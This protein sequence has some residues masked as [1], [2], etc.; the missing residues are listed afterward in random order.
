MEQLAALLAQQAEESR[1]RE[2]RMSQLLER[3]VS[4]REATSSEDGQ[5]QA[6]PEEVKFPASAA[7][8]PHLSSSASLRE[9][10][11][12]RHKFR[13]Y[14]A[15][16]KISALPLVEQKA[17]LSSVVDDEWSRTLRF[18]IDAADDAGLEQVLDAMEAHLR[19]QRNVIVDR[20]EFYARVQQPGESFDD[21]LCAVKEIVNFCDFCE[22][23][24][25]NRLR[26]RIVV[27]TSDEG[28]LKRMLKEKDLTLRSA[29][30]ICRASESAN[31]NS[32]AIRN[33]VDGTVCK[34]SRYRRERTS[35]SKG[36]VCFRC[37]QKNHTNKEKC[38]AVD[39]DCLNCGKL[40]HFAAVCRSP[41]RTSSDKRTQHPSK[42]S[43]T[44]D[45][46]SKKRA[47]DIHRVLSGVYANE[48]SARPAPKV[49]I[50]A[51]HPGGRDRVTWT[52][53]SGAEATVMGL[54]V[55]QSLG[56]PQDVLEVPDRAD[57]LAAGDYP[58]TC[59]GTFTSQLELGNKRTKT[60]VSV[61]KEVKGALLSWFDSVALGILPSDFPAQIQPVKDSRVPVDSRVADAPPAPPVVLPRWPHAHDPTPKQREEHANTLIRAFPRVFGSSQ[62]LREMDGGPMHIQLTEDAKPFAVTASR[63]I[64]YSWRAEIKAQL[65]D[66]LAKDIITE[67]DY[68][69][70]WC[71][72]IVPIAKKTTGVRLCVDLTR[73]NRYVKRPTYPVQSPNDAIASME[74][75]AAWFTTMD[76]KMGYF[77]IKIA[78][79]DQDLTCF[80]TPWG[81]FKFKRAPMGLVSSGDEYNR[82]GDQALG[83]SPRTVKIVDDILAYDTKY[84]DHLA[85]V[86]SIL[87]R[88]DRYGITLNADKFRFAR[89]EV[90][91]CG[92][93]ITSQGYTADF[94]KM[95]A[96]ADFP[97]P[98]NLTD[99]RSFMGLV[100]QLGGFSS[101]I[102]EASQ[103]LRDLLKPRNDWCWSPQHEEAFD[104]VKG[105]LVA[106]PVLAYFD[107]TLPT[108]LQTDAS[109][110]NGFGFVL[111]QKHNDLW[112]LV[113]CGSRFL[114]DTESRYAVIELELAAVL[115]SV[116]KCSTYLT[117]LPHFDL[118]V[119][120]RP[121]VPILN[122]KLLSEIENPR[123]QRIR[124]KLTAYTF[125]ARW[126]K[127]SL[128]SAP[129]ALSRAPVQDPE[130]SS[131]KPDSPEEVDPL[132]IAVVNALTD[133]CEE[134]IRLAPL[135][136]Q[137]L[138]KVR[139]AA[140]RD[141]E[142]QALRETIINGFPEHRHE[143]E[144]QLRSY[145]SV[146][147]QLALDE[148]LIVYGPRLLIPR[149]LRRET[150]ALLHDSHQGMDRT[151][152]RA[153]QTTY[154]PGID[155][156][157]ENVVSSCQ[158]C[159]P[160]LPKQQHE[161]LWQDDDPP[162]RV[163]QSV[164]ADYFHVAGR[165]YLVYVDRLSGWPYVTSCPREASAAHLVTCLR[166]IFADTGV[167]VTLRT[168]GGP[169][170]ASSTLRRFLA[171]WGV[172]H[173]VTSPYNPRANG[174]AEAAV[175]TVKKLITTTTRRGQLDE[176]EF[177]RGLLELR[178]TPSAAGRSPAQV[179][180]GHPM[181]SSVPA[182]HRSFASEWQRAADDCDVTA[183]RLKSKAKQR[184][185]S[186]ARPLPR[187][188]IGGYVDV[189]DH[190]SGRWDRV[191]VIVGIG[192]RRD[193]LIK[194]GSGRILWR[195][196]KFLRPHHPMLPE[197]APRSATT[198]VIQPERDGTLGSAPCRSTPAD[199]EENHDARLPRRT[200]RQRQTPKRLEVR[201][202][203]QTYDEERS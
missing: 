147:S 145:W 186:T 65:D 15:L 47:G 20:R 157:I 58:L 82:R 90:D 198:T 167:P 96:I 88:C 62:T 50:S 23:C 87:Q 30:D 35:L 168:D 143:L 141:E 174:H 55:A 127:G 159:R 92:Y 38:R 132:H 105:C 164:S 75:E 86:I 94:R 134:G 89:N 56:I 181:R 31:K 126:Q 17:V 53:D 115:W 93:S 52:P 138:E 153:R 100:N 6:S 67:V 1:R 176:D 201:W 8:A 36:T 180:F 2:E 178:N 190:A 131:G 170:F 117:G 28:A 103:P 114:T 4:R 59:L 12:W 161:P 177:A 39:K 149:S 70:A 148:D 124:E 46:G 10:D 63:T 116:K 45:T 19:G 24:I 81:R 25:D 32:A 189:Q 5:A 73:L 85:H 60:V 97:R 150:L 84:R 179:L 49:V 91:F 184:H 152:R 118:V 21:F 22:S 13:G 136:D 107:P 48:V 34:V 54:N 122:T 61:I 18:T 188:H 43:S 172:E 109:R 7:V 101:A 166:S 195:N 106:P 71:H 11:A 154:W 27:G 57:L 74:S 26:D 196:R 123:L 202:G 112:K 111:L 104:K 156:D 183:E 108:M 200:G 121:L 197:A 194:M 142:Y 64:P 66:L 146:R 120:H 191:G 9:F 129:D 158:R 77:Q 160:L 169:Q 199:A 171:R 135:K 173:R 113:Q 40:G 79:E 78:D 16:M 182:H 163:F 98:Q 185:D 69:T 33:T 133:V 68:P 14:V 80:I 139:A 51:T 187:L 3:A 72:P 44:R 29:I 41:A 102:A 95:K 110:R 130:P 203:T 175:K 128:H 99:L 151:K 119:D 165:T 192:S 37:G 76:A 155:R 83:D 137:T 162:S 193:Y 125:T 140:T 42:Q 144:P